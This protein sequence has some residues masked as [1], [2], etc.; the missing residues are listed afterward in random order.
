MKQISNM[1]TSVPSLLEALY[2]FAF[3][4]KGGVIAD[5][6]LLIFPLAILIPD[7]ESSRPTFHLMYSEYKLNKQG[8]KTQPC[9]ITFPI[10][11]L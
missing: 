6:K 10:L 4:H 2:F 7:C 3:C 5:L 8:D 11:N 1:Y 9:H